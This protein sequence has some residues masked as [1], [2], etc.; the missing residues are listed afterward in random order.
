MSASSRSASA[1]IACSRGVS[2]P[3]RRSPSAA[4]TSRSLPAQALVAI[5]L[6]VERG[7]RQPV[8]EHRH[9]RIQRRAALRLPGA[10]AGA[11][12]RGAV[13]PA[14]PPPPRAA[15]YLPA[16]SSARTRRAPALRA[17]W[18][19]PS[20]AV[21]PALHLG[22]FVGRRLR[23]PQLVEQHDHRLADQVQHL[24]LGVEI[25]DI[26]GR[27]RGVDEVEHD[28][29]LVEHVAHRALA[30]P[31]RAIAIAVPDLAHEPADR[32]AGLREPFREP[33]AVAEARRVPQLQAVALRRL[34]HRVA[35]GLERDVRFVA[36]F[37]DVAA[38]Q[39]ARE[40]GLADVGVRDEAERDG[41]PGSVMA[42]VRLQRASPANE[43]RA[44]RRSAD[45][46]RDAGLA[47]ACARPRGAASTR[48]DRRRSGGGSAIRRRARSAAPP[49]GSAP[50]ARRGTRRGSRAPASR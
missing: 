9:R 13:R 21:A 18:S 19:A 28:V 14:A 25:A 45:S 49:P 7:A 34:D 31:E 11:R 33:H 4:P 26:V 30:R 12:T 39:R 1:R 47:A 46:V 23:R 35:L 17:R 29:G 38:E 48:A 24:Q 32:V 41:R 37:A 42:A 3:S 27:L 40:R 8:G 36:H 20:D 10:R 16:P 5:R 22:G 44:P 6:A 43:L 2:A 15:T 50:P